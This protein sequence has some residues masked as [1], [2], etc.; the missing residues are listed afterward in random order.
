MF[1]GILTARDAE[2]KLKV[3]ALQ[4]LPTEIVPLNHTEV[5]DW[6]IAYSEL[7][8]VEAGKD[9]FKVMQYVAMKFLP[10]SG[11]R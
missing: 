1:A 4:Q 3:K 8:P 9:T 6:N 5:V 10:C 7:N 2:A 11:W